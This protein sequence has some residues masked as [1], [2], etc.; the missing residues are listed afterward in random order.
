[1]S[2]RNPFFNVS[3]NQ[4]YTQFNGEEL[5]VDRDALLNANTGAVL[6][7]VGKTYKLIEN[8]A[9]NDV[10]N[11]AFA[12]LPVEF[13]KDHM[14]GA[15]NR[16]QRDIILDGDQFTRVIGNDDVVK[17]KVSIWNGYDGRTA[18]GFALSAYRQVCQNGMMGWRQ[19]FGSNFAHIERDIIE[20]I[21]REFN[22]SFSGFARNFEV[23]DG[24]NEQAF[25]QDQFK[26]FVESRVKREDA[27]GNT[28]GYLSEKQV[29]GITGL[30][31][32]TLN[33]YN[34]DETKWG[35]YNVLTAIATH[36][37]EA[38]GAGSNIFSQGYKRMERLAKDFF[39]YDENSD[40][41]VIR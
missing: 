31:E 11:E 36:H 25:T 18:V 20:K 4:L 22:N 15:E 28:I 30:Y 21:Q 13:T 10:F 9:V 40:L 1:M 35:S 33:Q 34:D 29:E 27:E 16:W 8:G 32:P 17:T 5:A 14:N 37:T 38:R 23:W 39:T 7:T 2:E 3:R 19:M 41:F 6:G 26:R 24:W 12:E